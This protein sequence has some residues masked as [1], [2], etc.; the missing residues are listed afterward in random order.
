MV[1]KVNVVFNAFYHKAER[2]RVAGKGQEGLGSWEVAGTWQTAF[3]FSSVIEYVSQA[4]AGTH[5][6]Y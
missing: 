3:S 6:R 4:S 1:A 2:V 5:E